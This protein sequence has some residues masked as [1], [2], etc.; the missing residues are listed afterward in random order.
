[1]A[2]TPKA[3]TTD[4]L[5]GG[6]VSLRQPARGYRVN[7]DAILLAAFAAQGRH[8][9]FAVDLGAGVG[10]VA[11]GLHHLGAASRFALVEREEALLALAGENADEAKMNAQLWC[12]DLAGGLPSELMHSAD[13]VVSNPPFFD[14]TNSRP[15]QEPTKSSARFG[16]LAPFLNAAAALV[17]GPRTRVVFVYPSREIS[18]FLSGAEQVHLI[19][20][21]LRLVHADAASP[22][23]I[24]L[25]EL[26]RA[27]PGGLEVLPPLLEW[28]AKGVRSPE[29]AQLLAGNPASVG[30]KAND[31]K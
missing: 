23:R 1:M 21:R 17:S 22:A 15:S 7:V 3:T 9:K 31:R 10:S 16:D 27:K 12:L 4:S 25:L 20:K 5:Y 8:A 11:L 19:P 2:G 24:A 6:A 14:P 28:S 30:S 18:R 13:L 26:R 29:L